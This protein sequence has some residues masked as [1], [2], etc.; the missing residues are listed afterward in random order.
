MNI[1]FL[2][3]DINSKTGG[4]GTFLMATVDNFH[5]L[6]NAGCY[7]IYDIVY[8]E[9]SENFDGKHHYQKGQKSLLQAFLKANNINFIIEL[10]IAQIDIYELRSAADSCNCKIISMVHAKPDFIH[11]YPSTTSLL[12]ELK[13]KEDIK[14]KLFLILKILFFPIYKKKSNQKYIIWRKGLY[15]I[16]DKV[17]VLSK[18]YIDNYVRLLTLHSQHKVTSIPNPLRFN[19]FFDPMTLNLKKNDVLIVSRLEESSKFLSRI[20]K[21]WKIIENDSGLSDWNLRIVGGG[22][23]EDMYKKLVKKMKLSQVSFEGIQNPLEYYKNA[24]I[25]LMSSLHEGFPMTLL[26][27]TQMGLPVVAFDNF[28]SIHEL[29]VDSY[30]GLIVPK[31]DIDL[32]AEKLSLIMKNDK[33]R[34]QLA[35]NAIIHSKKFTDEIVTK[36]W[37]ILFNELLNEKK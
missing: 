37:K 17:V 21:V 29:V 12:W 23:D 36:Q 31:N 33:L 35:E 3:P 18:F 28:E 11:A 6:L 34:I 26:E 14:T 16:S 10:G 32:F 22:D 15:Q 24:K 1:A 13:K 5:R 9:P 27:A 2:A 30:N 7:L 4:H 20:F 19:E 8:E 25:F